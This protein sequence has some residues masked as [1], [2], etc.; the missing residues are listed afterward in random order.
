VRDMWFFGD[1]RVDAFTRLDVVHFTF[2]AR[3]LLGSTYMAGLFL[4]VYVVYSCFGAWS[5]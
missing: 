1:S 5:I 4:D 3:S 2:A